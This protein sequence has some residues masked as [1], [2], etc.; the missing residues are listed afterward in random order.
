MTA[1]RP[2]SRRR[3]L[4]DACAEIERC[5][6]TQFDPAVAAA[7]VEEVRRR[8]PSLEQASRFAA[9]LDDPELAAHRE[10]DEPLLGSGSLALI[11]NLTLLYSHRYLH[12]AAAAAAEA[13]VLQDSSFAIVFVEL[14]GLPAVNQRDGHAAGDRLIR[15][16][17]RGVQHAAVRAGAT[18][19]RYGGPRLAMLVPDAGA[20]EAEQ[21]VAEALADLPEDAQARIVSAASRDG[22]SGTQVIDR[23]RAALRSG[24]A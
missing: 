18:A 9:A 6:G 4:E 20:E 2:Y 24:V 10:G 22:E 11:D 1:D 14:A 12:E 5:A 23:A 15:M 17:A 21:L 3:P 7:F 13:A 19:C 8:P 16:A